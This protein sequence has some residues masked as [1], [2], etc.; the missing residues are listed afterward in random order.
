M[1]DSIRNKLE[2][3]VDRHEEIS[4]LLSD[5]ETMANQNKFRTLS[6]EYAQLEPVV[7]HFSLYLQTLSD[8]KDAQAMMQE[9]DPEMREM[10]KE[11][12]AIAEEN[13]NS[14]PL[15]CRNCCY[16]KIQMIN[17]ISFSKSAPAPVVMRLPFSPVIYFE[18][19][20][21]MLNHVAGRL[22]CSMLRKANMV[23][24]KKSSP[25]LLVMVPTHG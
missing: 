21:V 7:K 1:K 20:R 23:A 3:L 17:V 2:A 18:C 12:L 14:L 13:R 22:K 9:S 5:P 10:A 15:I 16:L 11:E 6:Q 4:G 25:G 19:T 24:I 8:L